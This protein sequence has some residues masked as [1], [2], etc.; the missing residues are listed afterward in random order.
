MAV[1]G[2]SRTS[3]ANSTSE[4][5]IESPTKDYPCYPPSPSSFDSLYRVSCQV[6]RGGFGVVYQ[7]SRR[8]EGGTVAVKYV[9]KDRVRRWGQVGASAVPLEIV[10]LL[11]VYNCERV[12]KL[13]DWFEEQDCFILVMEKPDNSTDLFDYI[14]ERGVLREETAKEI[15]KKT[16]KAILSCHERGVVHRDIKDENIL[17]DWATLEIKLIDFGSATFLSCSN[18]TSCRK[19]YD[20]TRVYSPPEWITHRVYLPLPGTVWSLGVLLYDM[21]QGD[22]PFHTDDAICS[23]QLSM[24]DNISTVCKDLISCCLRPCPYQRMLL[25]DISSHPWLSD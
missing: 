11:Q 22:I 5:I 16:I 19:D 13:I 15:F 3:I 14:S 10:L 20:G 25:G 7:G 2:V 6:G 4:T 18:C 8:G 23:G 17:I 24:A 9:W 21:L 12:V 1:T